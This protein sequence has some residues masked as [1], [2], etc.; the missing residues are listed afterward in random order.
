MRVIDAIIQSLHNLGGQ[1]DL[2]DIYI[3]VNKV[4]ATPNPSI[5]ARLYEHAS[6]CDAYKKTNPDL[7]ESTDGK[8]GGTWRFRTKNKSIPGPSTWL[9]EIID[10]NKFEIGALYKKKDIRLISGLSKSNGPREPWT[11]IVRLANAVLLFVNLDKTDADES[12]KFKDFFDG[13]DF[14]GSQETATLLKQHISR[15]CLMVFQYI[16]FVVFLRKEISSMLENL[17]QLTMTIPYRQCN[18]SL[19]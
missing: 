8:G 3:E 7:F 13:S 12:L 1:S 6:E 17:M 19:R 9:D 2:E 18:F 4:R 14:F 16:Y 10:I 11:G 15:K 5:R